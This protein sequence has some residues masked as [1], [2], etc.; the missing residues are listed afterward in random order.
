MTAEL[1]RATS[2]SLARY[3]EFDFENCDKLQCWGLI[4]IANWPTTSW[5]LVGPLLKRNFDV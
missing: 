1:S 4:F 5:N 2:M 3:T